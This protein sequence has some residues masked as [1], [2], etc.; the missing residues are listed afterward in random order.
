[1]AYTQPTRSNGKSVCLAV[2]RA[3]L[4]AA[5]LGALCLPAPSCAQEGLTLREIDENTGSFLEGL[6]AGYVTHELGHIVV[7][8]NFGYAVGHSGL[9]LTYGAKPMSAH[10]QQRIASAG[11]QAQW[12]GSELAFAAREKSNSTFAA[13]FV[14]M[15]LAISAAYLTVLKN[16]QMGDSAGYAHATGLSTNQIVWRAAIP[17]LLDGWRL[18]SDNVPGWVPKLSLAAKGIGIAAIWTQ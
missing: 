4:A 9:S 12:I 13:G 17:A 2:P 18:F 6:A 16:Q 15:H 8:E 11:F 10:D 7:A 14:C 1:M 3:L 5:F